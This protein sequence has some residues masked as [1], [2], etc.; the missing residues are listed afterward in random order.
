MRTSVLICKV[1]DL[2]KKL[3]DKE[4]QNRL[5]KKE[6][7]QTKVLRY[8]DMIDNVMNKRISMKKS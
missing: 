3:E 2:E 6:V 4:S 1:D 7:Q 5:L 8:S